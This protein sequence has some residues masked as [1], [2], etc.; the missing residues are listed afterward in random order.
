MSKESKREAVSRHGHLASSF[1]C[2]RWRQGTPFKTKLPRCLDLWWQNSHSIPKATLRHP[3]NSNGFLSNFH[4]SSLP[5]RLYWS[6]G[7]LPSQ[8]CQPRKAW[9]HNPVCFGS[10]SAR[11][12][13]CHRTTCHAA[14]TPNS[15]GPSSCPP[16]ALVWA[17]PS[18]TCCK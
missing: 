5:F 10:D 7:I 9:C 17:L 14:A 6:R 11:P 3:E 15:P 4:S 16:A 1:A 2:L 18:P 13:S 12:H 8:H